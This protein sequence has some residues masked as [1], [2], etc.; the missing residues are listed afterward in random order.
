MTE[1][2]QLGDAGAGAIESLAQARRALRWMAIGVMPASEVAQQ[3]MVALADARPDG[4]DDVHARRAL[5]AIRMG[6][7]PSQD[8]CLEAD[9]EVEAVID[10]LR[11]PEAERPRIRSGA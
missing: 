3:A 2:M 11:G 4:G 5:R 6:V 9:S 8:V 1:E 7:A 10:R